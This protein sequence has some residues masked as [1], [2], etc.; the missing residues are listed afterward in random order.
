MNAGGKWMR[1]AQIRLDRELA[2]AYRLAREVILDEVEALLTAQVGAGRPLSRVQLT[3]GRRLARLLGDVEDQLLAFADTA[4]SITVRVQAD[5]VAVAATHTFDAIADQM[6]PGFT[7]SFPDRPFTDLVGRLSNGRPLFTLLRTLA[8]VGSRAVREVLITGVALG[9]GP[10]VI[11]RDIRR[12]TAV[13]AH[14]AMTIA[15]T[16]VFGAY[17][18]AAHETM[19][20][21]DRVVGGWVWDAQLGPRTC[22]AC[23]AQHGTKHPVTERMETHPNCRCTQSPF[24]KTWAELGFS[25]VKETRLSLEAGESW[26][27]RQ[28]SSTQREILGSAKFEAYRSGRVTLSDFVQKT[29]SRDWGAGIREASLAS[30]LAKARR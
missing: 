30:A 8:P 6:P 25:G 10:R 21:N 22:A 23:I 29:G 12:A 20:A 1:E 24:T 2:D 17:R 27:A 5:A 28:P 14:R 13:P 7:P 11:A 19:T 3:R 15:R 16:E 9:R 4:E 26:F 18:G